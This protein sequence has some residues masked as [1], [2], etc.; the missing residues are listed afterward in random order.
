VVNPFFERLLS[1]D[2]V[3]ISD[4]KIRC[5][6]T[7][8]AQMSKQEIPLV[9][10]R[11]LSRHHRSRIK[12]HQ[13]FRELLEATSPELYPDVYG[14]GEL[15]S[16][17]EEEMATLLGK[18]ATLFF[19]SGTM[20]QQIALRIHTDHRRLARVAFHSTCHLEQ[21]EHK[22]YQ[23]LH[24]L[25]GVIAGV[26]H[27]G[28]S[29]ADLRA[30]AEPLGAL[31]LELPQRELGG[32]LPSWEELQE[33][34]QWAKERQTALHLDGA[35]LWECQPFYQ[36]SYAEICAP[37]DSVY[38]SFYKSIGGIAGAMLGGSREFIEEAKIWQRRFGGNLVQLYP[39]V[40]SAKA[41]MSERLC[42]MSLYHEKAKELA[43]A[44]REI[45]GIILAPE[46]PHTNMMR[47]YV[48]GEREGLLTAER[49][50]AREH[51]LRLFQALNEG[52][53]PGYLWFELTVGD[54]TLDLATEEVSALFRLLLQRA[55]SV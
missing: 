25:H 46:I 6:L 44:L 15:I 7:E 35:R 4:S 48:K 5:I 19:P 39:Y 27:R 8:G 13:V 53:V 36:K 2:L 9:C 41:G 12:P 50:I 42:K 1:G 17:F 20:A 31:L 30:I 18:E 32:T 16:S 11:Y 47:L 54:A 10:S 28:L 40:L 23:V 33:M 34:T 49:S 29:L 52:P 21:H 3:F 45:P 38:V 14:S 22:A 43:L 55:H 51:D 26:P 24:G 37:F